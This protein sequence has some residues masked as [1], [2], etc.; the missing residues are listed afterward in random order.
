MLLTSLGVG[1]LPPFPVLPSLLPSHLMASGSLPH[2][3][4]HLPERGFL[5]YTDGSLGSQGG[6]CIQHALSL[7]FFLVLYALQQ[8]PGEVSQQP[9]PTP[10]HSS[11][12]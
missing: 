5:L 3:P 10:P 12:G 2:N 6:P 7:R 9:P 1:H 4:F 8:V 11:D